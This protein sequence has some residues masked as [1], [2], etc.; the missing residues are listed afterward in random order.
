MVFC[1]RRG[2]LF[3]S[4]VKYCF[5]IRSFPTCNRV[6]LFPF[7]LRLLCSCWWTSEHL[8]CPFHKGALR[9]LFVLVRVG[10]GLTSPVSISYVPCIP[11]A[12]DYFLQNMEEQ[13]S[14]KSVL[15]LCKKFTFSCWGTVHHRHLLGPLSICVQV[16]RKIQTLPVTAPGGSWWSS[17]C[18]VCDGESWQHCCVLGSVRGIA[19]HSLWACAGLQNLSGS[20]D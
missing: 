20:I 15:N 4:E 11:V 3:S 12:C 18:C 7:P 13:W 19:V 10:T 6:L 9:S 1:C 16:V 5:C 14:V 17:C 2:F 8:S